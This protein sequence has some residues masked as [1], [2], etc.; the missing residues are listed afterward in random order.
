MRSK[1]ISNLA[2]WKKQPP[3]V[4][5]RIN[6]FR[7][8]S[9]ITVQLCSF[10]KM[11]PTAAPT[12]CSKCGGQNESI[13]NGSLINNLAKENGNI[14]VNLVQD[15][16]SIKAY[17]YKLKKILHDV[18]FFFSK[19]VKMFLWNMKWQV[20]KVPSQGSKDFDI[21]LFCIWKRQELFFSFWLTD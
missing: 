6:H 21:F 1:E 5:V 14:P 10:Q 19:K 9:R 11:I 15:V 7:F 20:Q 18:S 3:E 13:S 16:I 12:M 4:S 2:P 8:A 17:L